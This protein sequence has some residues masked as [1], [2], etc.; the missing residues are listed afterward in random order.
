MR[1]VQLPLKWLSGWRRC[2]RCC[3]LAPLLVVWL[4]A[5]SAAW[6][7]E[8]A[9]SCPVRLAVLGDSLSAGYGLPPQE[10]FPAALKRALAARGLEVEV[11]NAG[12]S[13]DTT[14]GG[15]ARLEWT[16]AAGPE[17]VI[18]ELGGNDALRGLDPAMVESNL[19]ALLTGLKKRRVQVLLTGMRA[20]RNLGSD[21]AEAFDGVFARLA[22][23]HGV[24]FYP[25]FLEGVAGVPALNLAD[26]IHPN[27]QGVAEI[28]SRMMPQVLELVRS[29]CG[30]RDGAA[31]P[32]SASSL[33]VRYNSIPDPPAGGSR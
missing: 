3:L 17:A 20:P 19:N 9:G 15:L 6:G 16:L 29:V 14:A 22:E 5:G 7:G 13:G 30:R 2:R 18:V 26:G 33:L 12:V 23:R 1:S 21:Y 11:I 31:A 24:A 25:F 28:V 4:A 27:P 8:G 32:R 10:A